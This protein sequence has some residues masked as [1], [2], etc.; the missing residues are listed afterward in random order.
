MILTI[1][2]YSAIYMLLFCPQDVYRSRLVLLYILY[3]PVFTYE[4]SPQKWFL[5]QTSSG[6]LISISLDLNDLHCM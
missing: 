2:C 3:I 4:F 5:G 6:Q 1:N